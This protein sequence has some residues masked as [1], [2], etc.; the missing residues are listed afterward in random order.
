MFYQN[1]EL[2]SNEI[3]RDFFLINNFLKNVPTVV[4]HLADAFRNNAQF[5]ID[6][7]KGFKDFDVVIKSEIGKLDAISSQILERLREQSDDSY[8]NLA[9]VGLTNDTLSAKLQM[10]DWLWYK[11]K[12]ENERGT[13]R[14]SLNDSFFT[15][16]I[17]MLKSV[18]KSLFNAFELNSDL[19]EEA[20]DLLNAFKELAKQFEL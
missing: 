5:E 8:K 15:Q 13:L 7:I 1:L 19:F 10:L 9:K 4:N 17:N 2:P 20:L 14:N 16:F 6:E 11:I 18:L 12:G 3:E